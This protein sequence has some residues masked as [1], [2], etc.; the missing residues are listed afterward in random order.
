MNLNHVLIDGL[1][2]LTGLDSSQD[3][4]EGKMDKY[5]T[6]SYQDER[7]DLYADNEPVSDMCDVYV[8]L[9]VPKDFDYFELKDQIRNYLEAEKFSVSINSW[10]EAGKKETERVRRI[11]FDCS[12]TK[13]R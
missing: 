9:F 7:P 11:V 13:K 1:E 10:L 5:I 4:Y 2:K 3:I 8:N 12:I 6:F